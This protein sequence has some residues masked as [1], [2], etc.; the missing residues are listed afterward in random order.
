MDDAWLSVRVGL[1]KTVFLNSFFGFFLQ[2]SLVLLPAC[3]FLLLSA[4]PLHSAC[5]SASALL[6]SSHRAGLC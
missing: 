6:S 1:E 4:M 5:A 3:V 2:H